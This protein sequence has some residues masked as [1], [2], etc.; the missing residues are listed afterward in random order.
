M[1]A[2][3]GL[4]GT[5]KERIT[6]SVKFDG[7]AVP[8]LDARSGAA[9]PDVYFLEPEIDV[10][11]D[12]DKTDI[13]ADLSVAIE[14]YGAI[15]RMTK[16]AVISLLTD[17][18]EALDGVSGWRVGHNLATSHFE[19]VAVEPVETQYHHGVCRLRMVQ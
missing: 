16:G 10:D 5:I 2:F 13:Y 15:A 9:T 12:R 3:V 8:F 14:C 1:S 17:V 19:G 7:A 6:A 18:G 4:T 11:V